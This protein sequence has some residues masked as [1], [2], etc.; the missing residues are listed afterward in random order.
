MKMN[1]KIKLT[2]RQILLYL[3][4]GVIHLGEPF[5]RHS[6][7]KKSIEDFFNWR[8][9]DKKKFSND[10]QR[11]KRE[12]Y[13]KIYIS[14]EK[15]VIEL[16]GKGKQRVE[17]FWAEEYEFQYPDNWDRKWRLVIFDIPESKKKNRDILR[18]KLIEIGF[19]RLQDSVFVF[20]FDCKLIIDYLK[21][22]LNI[23]IN[24]QYIIAETIETEIDLVNIFLQANILKKKMIS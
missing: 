11:L 5:D 15:N 20:P 16:S 23:K 3:T 9:M 13:I 17:L 12:G 7:Y 1:E 14:K 19:V 22:L 24:V 18:R 8:D 4:E 6:F 2:S 21:N 10:I